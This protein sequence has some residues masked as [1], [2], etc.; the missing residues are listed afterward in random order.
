MSDLSELISF[1][2]P[3][4]AVGLFV[5]DDETNEVC[6]CYCTNTAIGLARI[7]NQDQQLQT[8]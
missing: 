7:L 1:N 2:P 5:F 4:H 3:Y 6:E 8:P